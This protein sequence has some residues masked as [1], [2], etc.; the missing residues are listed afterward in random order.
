MQMN[1]FHTLEWCIYCI[2]F[3]GNK[4]V[5][6]LTT[7]LTIFENIQRL[8]YL[9]QLTSFKQSQRS[10]MDARHGTR[11]R[12]ALQTLYSTLRRSRPGKDSSITDDPRKDF[13]CWSRIWELTRL[14]GMK[15]CTYRQLRL[16]DAFGKEMRVLLMSWS[17]TPRA[18]RPASP[19][20]AHATNAHRRN[21]SKGRNQMLCQLQERQ[22]KKSKKCGAE[23]KVH[24][25][26]RDLIG[27]EELVR[28]QFLKLTEHST[29]KRMKRDGDEA[30]IQT[31]RCVLVTFD[32][33]NQ[34]TSAINKPKGPFQIE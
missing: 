12:S 8:E 16:P 28:L 32:H 9:Q 29:I 23:S 5:G 11:W 30:I 17:N 2:H 22:R 18:Y 19:E 26:T 31:Q 33:M 13:L 1:I 6:Q 14:R 10:R 27:I 21:Q 7:R 20:Q 34:R 24:P 25:P 3:Y 15:F 4:N